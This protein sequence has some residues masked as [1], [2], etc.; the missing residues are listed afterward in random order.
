MGARIDLPTWFSSQM[1]MKRLN[2]LPG[3]SAE[4]AQA[5]KIER[6]IERIAKV[7]E[8]MEQRNTPSSVVNCRFIESRSRPVYVVK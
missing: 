5:R 3:T 7:D 2:A 6:T 1:V 8:W 4:A